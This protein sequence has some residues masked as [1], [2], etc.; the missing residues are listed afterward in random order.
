LSNIIDLL[1]KIGQE[2]TL[3]D[4]TD[5]ELAAA[6]EEAGIDPAAKETLLTRDPNAIAALVGSN[7]NICCLVYPRP[8][9][10]EEDEDGEEGEEEGEED[11]DDDDDDDDEEEEEESDEARSVPTSAEQR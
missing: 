11:D 6:L 8:E 2:A 1:E 7:P 3:R 5:A 10:E 4:A 9:E